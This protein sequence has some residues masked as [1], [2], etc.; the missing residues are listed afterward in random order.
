MPVFEPTAREK[1][2]LMVVSHTH[3]DRE[4]YL[5]YQAF[6]VRLVGLFDALIDL[7]DSDPNY[8]HFMLDGHTIPLED[9]LEVRPDRFDDV[10]RLVQEGRLLIGPWYIIPDEFLP[11]GEALVRNIL[12]GHRVAAM[13]G[14]VMKVGYIPDP[15]GQIAHMPAI[16]NGFGIQD[17]TM[18]RGADDSLKTT[19]F[20]WRSPDGSE[21][22][23]VHKPAGY[24]IGGVLPRAHRAL[25]ARIDAIRDTLEPYATTPYLLVM[26][27]GDHLGPQPE[28]SSMIDNAN[29]D[30]DDA[31]IEHASLPEVLSAIRAY[32][33]DSRDEWP[34][35]QGEFRSGQRAHLLP[36]V[37]SARMWIKQANQECEDLLAHWAEPFSLWAGALKKQAGPEWVEPLPATTAH[38]PF[39]TSEDSIMALV[40]RA[41]RHLLENQ[42]HDSICG[43]SVDAV[44]DEMRQRYD[45]VR[46]IGDEVTRRA[47]RVI[48]AL[49]P[50]DALGTIAVFNPTPQP[51]TGFVVATL[52][53]DDARPVVAVIGPDGERIPAGQ[54]GTTQ[55]VVLP[56]G[57]PSGYD[58]RR[59][60]VGFVAADVPGYGYKVYRVELADE[61]QAPPEAGL[62]WRIEN[63][64]FVVEA[65]EDGPLVVTDKRD[66]RVLRGLNRFVDGGDRGD[67][68]NYCPPERDVLIERAA[69][70]RSV[71]TEAAAGRRTLVVEQTYRLPSRLSDD[72]AGRSDDA[73]E[74]P[75]VSRVTLTD[76]VPRID[77]RTTVE[78]AAEDHRLRVH[79]QSGLRA[80]VSKADQH[81][82]V[83]SRPVAL[84]AWD[85]QTWMEQ[86]LGT[87]P[88]KAFVSVDDGVHGLTIA[89][90]GLPEY[91]VID[92]D[93][94]AEIAVTLLRCVGWLSRDDLSTR[95][96]GAGPQ[97]RTPGAQMPGSHTFE[98]SIIPHAGDWAD[99]GAHVQAIQHLRPMRARW[100]RHGLGHIDWE[101][102]FVRVSSPAFQVSAIKRAE[103][104]DGIIVRLYNTLDEPAEAYVDVPAATGAVSLV[105]LNEDYVA[106]LRR[107]EH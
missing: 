8:R 7:F 66:G 30:L 56:A 43:C 17:A 89:N 76:G 101:G 77:V 73:V 104:G 4:W 29:M 13:F 74:T 90:R 12:R 79:F 65:D 20:F 105:N 95:R 94:G 61:P 86:P 28:L 36:G 57:A 106:G 70:T 42:P 72:R 16:L 2:H 99:A 24:G 6:R 83:V 18:W 44:H 71:R 14:P 78:N 97:L 21:V 91:E 27:G 9:Y 1:R 58:R 35:H 88:Q 10:Q 68:Y 19:E 69:T 26:N 23:T 15:F 100:N 47:L 25:M 55:T 40:D 39:P 34:V 85:P 33:V 102:A 32:I 49:A 81:F 92:A 84:P 52:P 38:M 22:L 31:I 75:I 98:Y 87:Y 41:W 48:A 107:D 60:D 53:W 96:G 103:D 62:D 67:E 82:G 64:F 3:W 51:A 50:N 37:L 80:R 46:E 59:A 54:V 63:E 93:G 45:W 5:P 11:G